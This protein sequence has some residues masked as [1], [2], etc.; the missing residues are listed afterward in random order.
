MHSDKDLYNLMGDS[1]QLTSI[2]NLFN[3][4][5]G[6]QRLQ[7]IR[8]WNYIQRSFKMDELVVI[9]FEAFEFSEFY[10]K[11]HFN[12]SNDFYDARQLYNTTLESSF[13][14]GNVNK[15]N[16]VF[17][18]AVENEKW[19][20]FF[21]PQ[22]SWS[23]ETLRESEKTIRKLQIIKRYFDFRNFLENVFN[24]N[25]TISKNEDRILNTIWLYGLAYRDFLSNLQ[26]NSIGEEFF[27]DSWYLSIFELTNFKRLL[28]S[29]QLVYLM[30]IAY[31]SVYSVEISNLFDTLIKESDSEVEAFYTA[32]KDVFLAPRFPSKEVQD[33]VKNGFIALAA[34]DKNQFY[35]EELLSNKTKR[36]YLTRF[37]K[38][39]RTYFNPDNDSAIGNT[40]QSI[41][42][43]INIFDRVNK[44]ILRKNTNRSNLSPPE[45]ETYI[46][47]GFKWNEVRIKEDLLE[48]KHKILNKS[49]VDELESSINEDWQNHLTNLGNAVTC[50][51]FRVAR[52]NEQL[53]FKWNTKEQKS[54][55]FHTSAYQEKLRQ[56]REEDRLCGVY[57]EIVRTSYDLEAAID[58]ADRVAPFHFQHI[59]ERWEI[60]L[61]SAL[62]DIKRRYA[63]RIRR[64]REFGILT[65]SQKPNAQMHMY[66]DEILAVEEEVKPYL[67]FVKKAFQSALPVRKI[68]HFDRYRNSHVGVEFD[69]ET[70]Y[71]Q[72]KWQRGEVMK[73]LKRKKVYGDV[74]QVNTF[75][76]DFSGSMTH[77]RM[78]NLFKILFLIITGL[79]DRKVYNSIHLFNEKFIPSVEL[80][81]K[82]VDR[83]TLF[84]VLSQISNISDN[85]VSFGGRGGTN[86]YAGLHKCYERIVAFSDD[87]F[88]SSK[89]EG[90]TKSIFVISDGEPTLGITDIPE[91]ADLITKMRAESDVSIKGIYIKPV[92]DKSTFIPRLFGEGHYVENTNFEEGVN[93]F[94]SIMTKTFEAQRKEF[95]N[96]KRASKVFGARGAKR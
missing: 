70:V 85:R 58:Y 8:R 7:F 15:P 65:G 81:L 2:K 43:R 90:I 37:P 25:P 78:R 57:I 47:N 41:I 94:V 48:C 22:P 28:P 72:N 52:F 88:A 50:P 38:E 63:K 40:I 13:F 42:G 46:K 4:I 39:I 61:R 24:D 35:L 59:Q 91:L 32:Y 16:D 31:E 89:E 10:W 73:V 66:L 71:D 1:S 5:S 6:N 53:F 51:F 26:Q 3:K 83:K 21:M 92:N 80:S 14:G 19:I 69:P 27:Q 95:K 17:K 77:V 30:F 84:K 45:I 36:S 76:L 79:S 54:V 55:R 23:N 11:C 75:C 96:K 18:D 68:T 93:N 86:I 12:S 49:E 44:T 62:A 29:E 34:G 56:E 9:D 20:G 33:G 87:L 60:E 74:Q 82:Y 64:M 67:T